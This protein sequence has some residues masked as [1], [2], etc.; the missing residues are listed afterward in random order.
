MLL[1]LIISITAFILFAVFGLRFLND[2][3]F[4]SS[5]K[6][7]F[8]FWEW[9]K[10]NDSGEEQCNA[11][12]IE[13]MGMKINEETV[14]ALILKLDDKYVDK[15]S[16]LTLTYEMPINSNMPKDE[17]SSGLKMTFFDQKGFIYANQS[18]FF[19]LYTDKD[20]ERRMKENLERTMTGP[21]V[22]KEKFRKSYVSRIENEGLLIA[23]WRDVNNERQIKK[24][25]YSKYLELI[26]FYRKN[27][28]FRY[29]ANSYTNEKVIPS[30]DCEDENQ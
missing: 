29:K 9:S 26:D 10:V 15:I 25:K 17:P 11:L 14:I 18:H 8:L 27:N 28:G 12:D 20:I 30:L 24:W 16:D 23:Y 19:V 4:R 3:G 2:I 1:N 21:F 6:F 22:D 7:N 13:L 5:T